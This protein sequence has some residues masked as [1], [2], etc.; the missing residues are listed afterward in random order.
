MPEPTLSGAAKSSGADLLVGACGVATSLLT[1][2]ILW[3]IEYRFEFAL[4]TLTLWFLVPIG[5]LG[6]GFAGA[7]GYYT[8]ARWLE[9]R[10]TRLLLL[11]VLL[12]SVTTFFLIHYLSY[13]TLE[14]DGISVREVISFPRY[15]DVVMTTTSMGLQFGG[16]AL[17][18]TG[19][20]GAF[21]YVAAL[22]Q[23][24][25][26]AVGGVTVW[27]RLERQPYCARCSRY[28]VWKGRSIRYGADVE[29]LEASAGTV[30]GALRDQHVATALEASETFGRTT[31]EAGD[32]ARTLF[33]IRYCRNCHQHWVRFSVERV[34]GSKWTETPGST[35][36]AFTQEVV[37]SADAGFVAAA[38]SSSR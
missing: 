32:D 38:R 7:S 33:E 26:F 34:V 2:L 25:G 13:A 24:A 16:Y 10:P 1:A 35:I 5:A 20:V 23:I 30:T 12:A 14:I 6:A 3:F 9:R 22:L 36:T 11:N 21:G 4:Y 29:E 15:L 31:F 28:L 17:G 8:G 27:R 19:E 18:S 37:D